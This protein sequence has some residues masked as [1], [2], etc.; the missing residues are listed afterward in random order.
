M[1]DFFDTGGISGTDFLKKITT[2]FDGSTVTYPVISISNAGAGYNGNYRIKSLSD[3]VLT[4]HTDGSDTAATFNIAS[5]TGII[6][7]FHLHN[8]TSSNSIEHI[9]PHRLL[10]E[11]NRLLSDYGYNFTYGDTD[12]V[13]GSIWQGNARSVPF[14]I[15]KSISGSLYPYEPMK[16]EYY[17]GNIKGKKYDNSEHTM[18]YGKYLVYGNTEDLNADLTATANGEATG[19]LEINLDTD[20]DDFAGVTPVDILF[21]PYIDTASGV[22]LLD[23]SDDDSL[24]NTTGSKE[25]IIRIT[26]Q[27]NG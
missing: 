11:S 16:I 23:N 17:T 2:T 5:K 8:N 19:I 1:T 22:T 12:L 9:I 3:T 13:I 18:V 21:R 20:G 27:E 10:Q 15:V 26:I 24:N 25:K 4:L 6:I 7:T 14:N